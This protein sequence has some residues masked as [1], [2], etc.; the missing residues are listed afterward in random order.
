MKKFFVLAL[1]LSITISAF[2]KNNGKEDQLDRL[3]S[4][5]TVLDEIMA[6]PDKGVPEEILRS[7]KCVA[8]VPS[9]LKGG[10][11]VGAAYGRGVAT[12]RTPDAPTKWSAPAFFRVEGGSFGLQIGAQAVDLVMLVMNDS[13]MQT[14]LSSKFKL[15]ADASA[16]AGPV[17]RHAEG[18]TDWKMRAEV[19]TYSRARGVFAGLTLNGAAIYADDDSTRSIYGRRVPTRTILM[20]RIET[21][22]DSTVFTNTVAKYAAQVEAEAKPAPAATHAPAK[23]K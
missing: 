16:A 8:V 17:G 2:G 3:Q 20:G 5:A 9:L 18:M 12:C 13:G 6:A 21:P 14:L 23:S 22:A 15:G 1:V 4:A 11:V 10:F 7:A 19:L